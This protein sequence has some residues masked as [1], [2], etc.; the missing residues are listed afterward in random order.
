MQCPAQR[1]IGQPLPRGDL[2]NVLEQGDRPT[3]VRVAEFLGRKGQE[4]P[5]QVLLVFVHRPVAPPSRLVLERL[6]VVGLGIRL[7]PVVDARAGYA[8][9]AGQVGDGTPP[10]ELQVGQSSSQDAR[11]QGL[12]ELAPEALALPRGQVESAHVLLLDHGSRS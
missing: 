12:R 4:N 7:D 2:Q 11:V 3:R 1:V 6:G 5:Q 9:H 10:V 8:E